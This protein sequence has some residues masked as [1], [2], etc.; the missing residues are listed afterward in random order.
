[1]RSLIATAIR[2]FTVSSSASCSSASRIGP[3]TSGRADSRRRLVPTSPVA[4]SR[5]VIGVPRS[6]IQ[7]SQPMIL[8][9]SEAPGEEVKSIEAGLYGS[10]GIRS[11]VIALVGI[12]GKSNDFPVL[13]TIF[14]SF[15]GP[16][17]LPLA[18]A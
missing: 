6:Q 16:A 4:M 2:R 8:A 7:G 9:D 3:S 10:L 13:V 14:R 15:V 1:M 18:T 17:E 12:S 5:K 11:G